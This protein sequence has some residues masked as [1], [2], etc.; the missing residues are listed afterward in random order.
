MLDENQITG[1]QLVENQKK[2]ADRLLGINQ[3]APL[4]YS[5]SA[6]VGILHR[7]GS[8]PPVAL[9]DVGRCVEILVNEEGV[10]PEEAMDIFCYTSLRAMRY[11]GDNAEA[12]IHFDC[13]DEACY[14]DLEILDEFEDGFL[15]LVEH[16]GS[17]LGA[18]GYDKTKCLE[19]ILQRDEIS[20]NDAEI[21][22]QSIMTCNKNE[23]APTFIELVSG[24]DIRWMTERN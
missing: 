8:L 22:L 12:F 10:D 17:H 13:D 2:M 14:E 21:Q 6:F 20:E 4:G 7:C 11:A 18:V 5:V 3:N 15:G 9:Y 1:K 24:Y 19:I 23:H 16:S